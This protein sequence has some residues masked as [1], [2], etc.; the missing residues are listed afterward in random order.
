[1]RPF[2]ST[3][4]RHSAF[5]HNICSV[6]KRGITSLLLSEVQGEVF[7]RC[8]QLMQ[9]FD[10]LCMHEYRTDSTR[11]GLTS[12]GSTRSDLGSR[13]G[14]GGSVENAE[15]ATSTVSVSHKKSPLEGGLKSPPWGCG[16]SPRRSQDQ[17]LCNPLIPL[18]NPLPIART[19]IDCSAGGADSRAAGTAGGRASTARENRA[20]TR[21]H[22]SEDCCF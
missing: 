3:I 1:M 16:Q 5:L 6:E 9:Y 11:F 8:K 2:L 18:E 10:E 20:E 4:K 22:R 19:S 7:E 21:G 13:H 14:F 17:A 15:T 12:G